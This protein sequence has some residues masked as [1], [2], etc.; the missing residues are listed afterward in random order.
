M[1]TLINQ[2]FHVMACCAISVT[3]H[4]WLAAVVAVA[5]CK[6]KANCSRKSGDY[7]IASSKNFPYFSFIV[8][9]YQD[10]AAAIQK[11]AATPQLCSAKYINRAPAFVR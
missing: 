4:R 7:H 5:N 9:K 11:V 3:T 1:S 8:M 2:S 6:T 10:N